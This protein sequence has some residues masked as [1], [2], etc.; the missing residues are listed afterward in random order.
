MVLPPLEL[1]SLRKE[2][3]CC[4]ALF[5]FL[6][7]SCLSLLRI[8]HSGA[9]AADSVHCFAHASR[10]P[11]IDRVDIFK[12]R[13]C[14]TAARTRRRLEAGTSILDKSMISCGSS[15]SNLERFI[16]LIAATNTRARW[17]KGRLRSLYP[18]FN[19]SSSENLCNFAKLL[20]ARHAHIAASS[21]CT[22][23]EDRI[24]DSWLQNLMG[25]ARIPSQRC[26]MD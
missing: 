16:K 15:H 20:P 10:S 7:G 21:M 25:I 19:P 13:I 18:T 24:P 17:T 3:P 9:A 22:H 8:S 2:L 1:F 11:H 5:P 26:G 6:R 12:H 14:G 23:T 4:R